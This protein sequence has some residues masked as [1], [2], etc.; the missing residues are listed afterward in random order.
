[1][2]LRLPRTGLLALAFVVSA[3]SSGPL[4]TDAPETDAPAGFP[5]HSVQQIRDAV[6]LSAGGVRT[7]QSDG[8]A[9]ITSPRLDQK[10]SFSLRATLGDSVTAILRGPFGIEGGRAVATPDSFLAADRLNRKLIVGPA[11]AA[12]RYLPGAGSAERVARAATGLLVPGAGVD[13][14]RG[15]VEGRYTLLGTLEGG[16]RRE[17]TVDPALW[18]VVR[19]REFDAGGALVGEQTAEAFDTVD[20]FVIPRRVTLRAGE[21][22]VVIEHRSV[23]LNVPVRH[24]WRRPDGYELVR[25]R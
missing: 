25:V 5:N 20:G 17:Y 2:T 9:E 14:Q 21:T 11:S 19:V 6:R 8:K 18:R 1:M 7:V 10:V 4:V 12:E 13:W 22:V 15:T 24:L 23:E 3:C 16:A